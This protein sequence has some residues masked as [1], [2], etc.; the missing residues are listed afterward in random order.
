MA[1]Y[2]VLLACLASG[3]SALG[4][5]APLMLSV[6][7]FLL[8]SDAFLHQVDI[9]RR[10]ASHPLLLQLWLSSVGLALVACASC[11]IL[12]ALLAW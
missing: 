11:Y 5:W 2:I 9:F 6:V 8:T 10:M 12:G 3:Y 7:F 1:P 4:L